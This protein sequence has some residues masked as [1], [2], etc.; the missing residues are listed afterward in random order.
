MPAW[1]H[2]HFVRQPAAAGTRR[3]ACRDR[4]TGKVRS[5]S[6]YTSSV[7]VCRTRSRYEKGLIGRHRSPQP[8]QVDCP[9]SPSRTWRV[10][11]PRQTTSREPW[12]DV[13]QRLRPDPRL[14][15]GRQHREA[16]AEAGAENA[17]PLESLRC[18]PRHRAPG[19]EHRLPAHLHR[20]RDVGADDVVGARELRRHARIVIGQAQAQRR[21]AES[22]E[23]PR[24]ADV[25]L[26]VGV[27]L[28]QH[29]DGAAAALARPRPGF[30]RPR[31]T[32]A[33]SRC[34]SRDAGVTSALG[35]RS[36]PAS[37]FRCASAPAS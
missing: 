28:R 7:R 2:R 36:V 8:L 1:Q 33:R 35:N 22:R 17:D 31:E 32:S 19:V 37:P 4:S 5:Y 11:R 24:Q 14:V 27:P 13:I 23:Q 25:P 30:S 15:R 20:P 29:D 21:D 18:Q 16:R 9:S 10:D 34:C 6:A 3:S 12:R 26:G